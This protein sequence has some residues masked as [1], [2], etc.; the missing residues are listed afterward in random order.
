MKEE[1]NSLFSALSDPTRRAILRVL[2]EGSQSA[3]EIAERFELTKPTL[4]HHFKKLEKAGLVRS[5]K[6]GN[7]V[8]YELQTNLLEELA[9]ELY[10]LAATPRQ[11]KRKATS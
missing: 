1:Q 11:K 4:S 2:R 10:D 6:E 3:G 9:T 5:R 7:H 8:I